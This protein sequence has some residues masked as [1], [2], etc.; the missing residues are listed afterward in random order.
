M[1]EYVA[2]CTHCRK[3]FTEEEI[4]NATAC[5]SCGTTGVPADPREKS[6]ATLTNHEWRLLCIW[7]SNYADHIK[8]QSADAPKVIEGIVN[9]IRKQNPVIPPLTIMEEFAQVKRKYPGS[10]LIKGDKDVSEEVH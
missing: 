1:A 2:L 9:E 10:K 8:G 6:T 3:Y 5:P 4:K 7:A